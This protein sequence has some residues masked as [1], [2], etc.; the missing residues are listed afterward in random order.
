VSGE[1]K[2]LYGSQAWT[3]SPWLPNEARPVADI[4]IDMIGRNAPSNLLVT[5]S[6]DHTAYNGLTKLAER[7]LPKEG[8]SEIG[9]ADYYYT[10][11][12]H[13]NFAKL[14]IP[15][16]FLFDNVHDDYHKPT[17]DVEKIDA[18]KCRRV[19]RTVLRMINEMQD[20]RL[21]LVR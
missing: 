17:D 9:S 13:A 4:N 12:D 10:R 11:S 2:G 16:T 8:F 14:G 19:V 21:D 15:V 7:C 18:D 1:E 5:P 20:E 6:R 3:S